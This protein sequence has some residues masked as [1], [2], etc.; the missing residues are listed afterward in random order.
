[1]V[2]WAANQSRS[3]ACR[4]RKM[5]MAERWRSFESRPQRPSANGVRSSTARP[6]R[7]PRS[8]PT[9]LRW[10][11]ATLLAL[12]PCQRL[13]QAAEQVPLAGVPEGHDPAVEQVGGHGHQPVRARLRLTLEVDDP[14]RAGRELASGRLGQPQR[15]GAAEAMLRDVDVQPWHRRAD[16][17]PRTP[18]RQ[19]NI[20]GPAASVGKLT[21]L[22]GPR[23]YPP[24]AAE[25]SQQ[26]VERK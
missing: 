20:I 3:S 4:S 23:V 24:S 7:R 5:S 15:L 21:V 19:Q 9:T 13:A 1:M 26:V 14:H 18:T 11:I 22:N 10:T 8:R 2:V 17:L 25:A 6:P 12:S 16:R